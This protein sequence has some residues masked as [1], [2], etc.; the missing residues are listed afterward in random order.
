MFCLFCVWA[1]G[2]CERGGLFLC[3]L[4]FRNFVSVCSVSVWPTRHDVRMHNMSITRHSTLICTGHRGYGYKR[5]LA[6]RVLCHSLTEL[7]EVP[8]KGMGF[9]QK[10]QKFQVRVPK[11]YRTHQSSRTGVQNSQKFRAG[12]KMLYRYSGYCGH[13]RQN[14]QKFRVWE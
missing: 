9:L 11:C 1:V 13:G 7:T 4:Y 14:S 10:F 5:M 12:T 3:I 2:R 6:L 8:G